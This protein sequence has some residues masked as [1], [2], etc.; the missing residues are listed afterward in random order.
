M[1]K[2][3]VGPDALFIDRVD[4][5]LGGK[6]EGGVPGPTVIEDVRDYRRRKNFIVTGVNE[7]ETTNRMLIGMRRTRSNC[8]ICLSNRLVCDSDGNANWCHRGWRTRRF[9]RE[10]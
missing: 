4:P 10:S 2:S 3:R 1:D 5:V 6:F 7:D 9:P 8:A